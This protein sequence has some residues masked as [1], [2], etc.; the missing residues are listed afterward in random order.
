VPAGTVIVAPLEAL[1]AATAARSEH[2]AVA[3]PAV[4]EAPDVRSLTVPTMY[5]GA[6]A[7][8]TTED[9]I[10]VT[11][12]GVTTNA[13]VSAAIPNPTRFVPISASGRS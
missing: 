6:A 5:C 12:I 4:Q 10:G 3:T 13:Q 9:P 7:A 11:R 1:A 8:W 2:D